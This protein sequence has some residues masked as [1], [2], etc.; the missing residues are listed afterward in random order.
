MAIQ[1]FERVRA[2]A[3]GFPEV[4]ERL[5]HGAP[6]FFVRDKRPICYFHDTN[7]AGDGRISLMCPAPPGSQA[8]RVALDP[9]VFFAPTPSASG[10]FKDWI[11]ANVDRLQESELDWHDIA[12]VIE[13]A[14]RVVAPKKL[15]A[16][17][18]ARI[19]RGLI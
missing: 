14:Y 10:V 5:S 3:L 12:D 18:E 13:D 4:N 15:I 1:E 16:E 17:L 8:A 9:E 6:S 19:D 2:I 7:F 11:G